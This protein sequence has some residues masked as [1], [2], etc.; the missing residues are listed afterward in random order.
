MKLC[1]DCKTVIYLAQKEDVWCEHQN[2][3]GFCIT[4]L[5]HVDEYEVHEND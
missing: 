2:Y 3:I 4:C 5:K 1:N